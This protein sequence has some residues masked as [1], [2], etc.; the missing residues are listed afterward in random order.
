MS[1]EKTSLPT[2]EQLLNLFKIQSDQCDQLMSMFER[3]VAVTESLRDEVKAM[4]S[5]SGDAQRPT[6]LQ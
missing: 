1:T 6:T 3:I 2:Y 5:V 4:R